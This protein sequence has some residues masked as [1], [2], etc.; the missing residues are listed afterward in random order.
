MNFLEIYPTAV[1]L[2]GISRTAVFHLKNSNDFLA[3]SYRVL[4]ILVRSNLFLQ[5][6]SN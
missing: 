2:R 6:I 4:I 1:Q 5:M 3:A